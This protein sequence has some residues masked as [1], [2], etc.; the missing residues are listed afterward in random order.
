MTGINQKCLHTL[1]PPNVYERLAGGRHRGQGQEAASPG[2]R[3]DKDRLSNADGNDD[4]N[5]DGGQEECSGAE[6][7]EGK[8]EKRQ[9]KGQGAVPAPA[10]GLLAAHIPATTIMFCCVACEDPRG[11]LCVCMCVCVRA[12]VVKKTSEWR[13]RGM[14]RRYGLRG[15]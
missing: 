5:D 13:A 8:A 11:S 4:G 3:E 6:Q 15:W 7:R 9:G 1:L 14:S 10:A 12:R 2:T